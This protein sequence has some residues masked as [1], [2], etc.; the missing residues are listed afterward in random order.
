MSDNQ[1]NTGPD[2]EPDPIADE[3]RARMEM[4]QSRLHTVKIAYFNRTEMDGKIPE[5]DDVAAV[6]KNLINTNYE[7]QKQL[8]GE[9]KMKMSVARLL[10]SSSR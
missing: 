10:R 9:V 6:A 8:Y 7:L 1:S 4:L 3:I 2:E 5:Y